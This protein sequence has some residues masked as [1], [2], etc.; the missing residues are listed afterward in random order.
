MKKICFITTTR[1]DYGMVEIMVNEAQNYKKKYQ[2]FL[3]ISGNHNDNFF[4]KSINEIKLKKK[5]KFIEFFLIKEI[6]IYHLLHYLF[7]N[8]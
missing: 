2:I 4:G 7:Q 8:F 5:S 6:R 3:I 1:A